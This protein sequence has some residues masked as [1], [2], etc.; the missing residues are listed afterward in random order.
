MA[1]TCEC[2][3]ELSVS[4]KVGEFLYSLL[5]VTFSRRTV[6]CGVSE[7]GRKEERNFLRVYSTSH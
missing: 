5:K 7:L 3:N 6:L 2:G 1:G 4:I